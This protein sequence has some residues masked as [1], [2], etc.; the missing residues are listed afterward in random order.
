M[1]QPR[2]KWKIRWPIGA[3]EAFAILPVDFGF[4]IDDDF[5]LLLH[6]QMHISWPGEAEST[7]ALVARAVHGDE[8][9][10][11]T[12]ATLTNPLICDDRRALPY[13]VEGK[14]GRQGVI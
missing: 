1:D 13:L 11:Q 12:M 3:W 2:A 7:L 5:I 6:A 8:L 14:G 10:A 4:K 9:A